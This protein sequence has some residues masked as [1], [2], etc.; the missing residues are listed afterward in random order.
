MEV[1]NS[2]CQIENLQGPSGTQK[3]G[4]VFQAPFS[5]GE[6]LNFQGVIGFKPLPRMIVTVGV[7]KV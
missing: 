7:V 3:E 4:I 2:N 6:L 5:R 1:E